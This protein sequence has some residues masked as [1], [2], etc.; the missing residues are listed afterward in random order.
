MVIKAPTYSDFHFLQTVP[1]TGQANFDQ[2]LK[3]ELACHKVVHLTAVPAAIDLFKF[4]E[5]LNQSL[6]NLIRKG[7]DLE[8]QSGFTNDQWLDVRYEPSL[9]HT[10][11]HSNTRQPFHTDGAY[12]TDFEFNVVFLFCTEQS[13]SGGAT[14]F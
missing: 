9:A 5:T 2:Q 8:H 6:G 13:E 1:F 11:R 4:Y 14:I 7:E 10:F 3:K 12:I